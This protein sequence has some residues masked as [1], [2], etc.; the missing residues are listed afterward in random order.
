[1]EFIETLFGRRCIQ[2]GV[3][4]RTTPIL[5][6]LMFLATGSG[7]GAKVDPQEIIQRFARKE[8]EFRQVW[9]QYTYTQHIRFQVL[10][11]TGRVREEREMTIEIF[12]TSDGERQHRIVDDRGKLESL[13]LTREDLDDALNL[14]PFALTTEELPQYEVKYQGEEQVDELMC[15]VFDVKPKRIRRN[16]RYFRGRIWVDD[17]DLQIVMTK[18]KAV[19][20]LGN[21]KFPAFETLRQQVDGKYWFPTWSEADDI[22][23]FGGRFRQRRRVHI[24]ELITYSNF[25]KF[26]VGTSIEFGEV[27]GE[28]EPQP[29]PAP[30]SEAEPE[31]EAPTDSKPDPEPAPE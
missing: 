4:K 21:N 1:M 17:V 24:R 19:P 6:F 18:G 20:D 11:R 3:M 13:I 22:L 9:Q 8:S 30:E 26:E 27:V 15:Y 16:R 25:K 29:E 12:F 14:Q 5:P 7:T 10:T 28:P 2:F 31:P 23:E